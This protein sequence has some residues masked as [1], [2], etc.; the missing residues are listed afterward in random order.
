MQM[1][2]IVLKHDPG[3]EELAF[4]DSD[5]PP[6]FFDGIYKTKPQPS[7][8]LTATWVAEQL[9]NLWRKVKWLGKQGTSWLT[10]PVTDTT[11][12]MGPG[13]MLVVVVFCSPNKG[14]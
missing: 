9:R 3:I 13:E 1:G 2:H 8:M 7:V 6:D 12:F 10:K 5:F 14:W 4:W 11:S